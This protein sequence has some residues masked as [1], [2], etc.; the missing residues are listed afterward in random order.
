MHL[1]IIAHYYTLGITA[2]EGNERKVYVRWVRKQK[3]T[4]T[5]VFVIIPFKVGE[6]IRE[7]PRLSEERAFC[8]AGRSTGKQFRSWLNNTSRVLFPPLERLSGVQHI[9]AHR[10]RDTF[11]VELWRKTK[12]I[13]FVSRALGHSS[14]LVT[15]NHYSHFLREDQDE[16]IKTML[17]GGMAD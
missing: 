16:A 6:L 12:D 2:K 8:P 4:D 13:N 11:A 17:E 7:A 5:P 9:H 15:I 1:K 10:F 3:K 14:V